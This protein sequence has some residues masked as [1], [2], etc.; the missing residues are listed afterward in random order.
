MSDHGTATTAYK[1]IYARI[2]RRHRQRPAQSRGARGAAAAPQ[3]TRGRA[4]EARGPRAPRV[5]AA[6]LSALCSVRQPINNAQALD[7]VPATYLPEEPGGWVVGRKIGVAVPEAREP[8][9][10]AG[11]TFPPGSAGG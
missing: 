11:R 4:G 10:Q 5:S 9:P 6:I 7:K 2:R 3:I 8:I 1:H